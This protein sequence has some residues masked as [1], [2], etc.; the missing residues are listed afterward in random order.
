MIS[1]VHRD[2]SRQVDAWKLVIEISDDPQAKLSPPR[3]PLEHWPKQIEVD[4]G[5]ER[6]GPADDHRLVVR[7]AVRGTEPIRVNG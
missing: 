5:A 2:P 1:L 3:K 6:S 4:A 7:I